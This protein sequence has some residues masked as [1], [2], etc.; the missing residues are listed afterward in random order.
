M[1]ILIFTFLSF[2]AIGLPEG[3]LGIAWPSIRDELGLSVS[4]IGYISIFSLVS[5]SIASFVVPKI[6]L[7]DSIKAVI[8]LFLMSLAFML[9]SISQSF[10]F[11]L[12]FAAFAGFSIAIVDIAVN[13]FM[14][15]NFTSRYANWLNC[16]FG[17]GA[18]ISPLVFSAVMWR[19][20]YKII[21]LAMFLIGL[22]VLYSLIKRF[23]NVTPMKDESIYVDGI[24]PKKIVK[25]INAALFFL[26]AGIEYSIGML[27]ITILIESRSIYLAYAGSFTAV[28]FAFTITG[29]IVF[30]ILAKYINNM[31]LLRIGFLIASM[32]LITIIFTNNI[33][34][35]VLLGLGM[36]PVFPCLMHETKA[37]A[38]NLEK[39]IGY[40]L[41]SLGMGS[42]IIGFSLSNLIEYFMEILF[43]LA[44]IMLI[45]MFLLNERANYYVTGGKRGQK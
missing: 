39:Q 9:F 7:N 1:K 6:K 23:W 8:G 41:A 13:S 2:I 43:P 16:F 36:G 15:K 45:I 32:G 34:A 30:G 14:T 24:E 38:K 31:N 29:R 27:T 3:A 19:Y 11:I 40:Q 44:L 28:Y 21:S 35:M 18:T 4:Y 12:I 42:A 26:M 25:H 10:M 37:R 5:Y 20:G 22:L 33:F 17:V